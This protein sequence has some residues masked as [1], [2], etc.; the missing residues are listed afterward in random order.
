MATDPIDITR[1]QCSCDCTV[2][3]FSFSPDVIII[4]III[5]DADSSSSIQW[6]SELVDF[7]L[8]HDSTLAHALTLLLLMHCT[9]CK[10][11]VHIIYTLYSHSL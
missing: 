1:M 3:E 7:T 11:T 8:V 9:V 6:D 10:H 4:I 5:D 2:D